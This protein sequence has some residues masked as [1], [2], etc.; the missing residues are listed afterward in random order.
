VRGGGIT[1]KMGRLAR[2]KR[3]KMAGSKPAK[4]TQI[5]VNDG[6]EME[7]IKKQGERKAGGYQIGKRGGVRC[8]IPKQKR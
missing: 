5:G 4:K 2:R 3:G 8:V 6:G 1:Q 7:T